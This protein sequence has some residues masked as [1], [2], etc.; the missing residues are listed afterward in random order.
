MVVPKIRFPFLRFYRIN[1][2]RFAFFQFHHLGLWGQNQIG[3]VLQKKVIVKLSKTALLV[4]K[5]GLSSKKLG[6]FFNF[7]TDFGNWV[8]FA[9]FL[10]KTILAF[11]QSKLGSFCK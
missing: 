8:R 2:L 3:F 10:C 9:F 11:R 1:W 5:Q 6:S 7:H 4:I